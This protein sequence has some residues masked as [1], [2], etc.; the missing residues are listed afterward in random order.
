MATAEEALAGE[1]SK[2]R[3]GRS[4]ED[5]LN[6]ALNSVSRE[7]PPQYRPSGSRVEQPSDF[8]S[9]LS[10]QIGMTGR[11]ILGGVGSLP[12]MIADSA[13]AGSKIGRLLVQSIANKLSGNP[14]GFRI[15]GTRFIPED[16]NAAAILGT[17]LPSQSF[18]QS[19][20]ALFGAPRNNMEHLVQNVGGAVAGVGGQIKAA[21]QLGKTA[22]STEG[23]RILRQLIEGQG[24]QGVGAVGGAF[25]GEAAKENDAGPTGTIIA[26]ILGNVAGAKLAKPMGLANP[27][28]RGD[29]GLD[30]LAN[31]SEMDRSRIAAIRAGYSLPPAE[32]G[33]GMFANAME[34]LSGPAKM[35]GAA[36]VKNE[37]V[38]NAKIVRNFGLP[39]GTPLNNN[40]MKAVVRDAV[41]T[42][43]KPISELGTIKN[44][45]DYVR[46]IKDVLTRYKISNADKAE[47]AKLADI[48]DVFS[49][50]RFSS[51]SAIDDI[52]DLRLNAKSVLDR[53]SG[54]A[55]P[56]GAGEL[57]LAKIQLGIAN[58][59]ENQIE[60]HLTN[61]VGAS[62]EQMLEAFRNARKTVAQA[63]I[64][65][66][67]IRE[68]SGNVDPKSIGKVFQK[69]P[70]LLTGELADIG[71]AANVFP[72][73]VRA[74]VAND[75]TNL[76]PFD[77][78]GG[79]GVG[80]VGAITS[81]LSGGTM[82]PGLVAGAAIPA[83]RV[84]TR[85]TMLSRP[86]QLLAAQALKKKG[87]YPGAANPA[88]N[89]SMQTIA[90]LMM[91]QP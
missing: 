2:L 62:G 31:P 45:G 58:A 15:E 74:S 12:M 86:M 89:A 19:L 69:S 23:L 6:A 27:R 82:T 54:T 46:E 32:G 4:A 48:L 1:M 40:T 87:I 24:Q 14:S 90:N 49:R 81:L 17:P 68:G 20:N 8:A 43:Y 84:G 65:D 88:A 39:E 83:F 75:R 56:P 78:Y 7:T 35:Q 79:S 10:H 3:P 61:N 5:A 29:E 72:R 18:E 85:K 25:A 60:R 42:G 16:M 57:K 76:S 44:D 36:A 53:A 67:A 9:D 37:A 73:S 21:E 63:T 34:G 91:D 66:N 47:Q 38:T 77:L 11:A 26:S 80:A 33:G 55:S 52:K 22:T 64:V 50:R 71:R 13:D 51:E 41:E 70:D 59:I 30:A 28:L